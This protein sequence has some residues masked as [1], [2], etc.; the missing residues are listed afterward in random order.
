MF[1]AHINRFLG[2]GLAEVKFPTTT[3]NANIQGDLKSGDDL[4]LIVTSEKPLSFSPHSIHLTPEE[5]RGITDTKIEE[6]LRILNLQEL[7]HGTRI[8]KESSG[9]S[10]RIV[11][12]TVYEMDKVLSSL[13][14][15]E[16]LNEAVY[17]MNLMADSKL[18]LTPTAFKTVLPLFDKQLSILAYFL[19]TIE[20]LSDNMIIDKRF[21]SD[22][23]GKF[24]TNIQYLLDYHSEKGVYDL[25][26]KNGLM[27]NRFHKVL[28][29]FDALLYW[30][31]VA[32]VQGSPLIVPLIIKD[33]STVYG[34]RLIHLW[35]N[36]L[37]SK[38]TFLFN[39][40]FRLKAEMDG[41][42]MKVTYDN[43]DLSLDM[44]DLDSK[45]E[46]Y[47]YRLQGYNMDKTLIF[48]DKNK[49]LNPITS[50][51]TFVI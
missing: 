21:V 51:T 44:K 15:D 3:V 25:L 6:I 23:E 27:D 24:N 14:E 30:N 28:R 26:I 34:I 20:Y 41:E 18:P 33:D 36:M 37:N 48:L 7:P 29:Y 32:S 10:S 43:S 11:R 16:D 31:S 17:I 47:G 46:K 19:R 5:R 50:R 8:V 39:D 13:N 49:N 2:E 22:E 35:F 45:M 9:L 38:S 4:Y 1:K 40:L 12:I 42:N